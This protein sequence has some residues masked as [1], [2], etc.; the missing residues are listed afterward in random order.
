SDYLSED[1]SDFSKYINPSS[2]H[3][4][5]DIM[6]SGSIPPNP[7]DLLEDS[8]MGGLLTQLRSRYDYIIIDS[9][10][11]MMVSDT[12]HLLTSSDIVVY[13]VRANYTEKELLTYAGSVAADEHVKKMAF[14]LNDVHKN[15][16]R[17]GYGGK[18]S[19]GYEADKSP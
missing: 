18:Y 16:M 8:K 1:G 19:Y 3:D 14:V 2:L 4:N 6:Q 9:A 12:F 17:Y 10:P 7:T 11:M 5:L 13:V 15:E